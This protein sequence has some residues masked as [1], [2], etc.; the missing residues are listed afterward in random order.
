MAYL[1]ENAI[2]F[3]PSAKNQYTV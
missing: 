1:S 3:L 2:I